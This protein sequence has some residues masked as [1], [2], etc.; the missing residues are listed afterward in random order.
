[1]I[2]HILFDLDGTLLP[3]NQDK[4]IKAYFSGI[5]KQIAPLGYDPNGLIEG[6]WKGTYNMIK[7]DGSKTNETVFLENFSSIFG[8]KVYYDTYKFDEF[9]EKYFD[10]VKIS[11]GYNKEAELLIDKLKEMNFNLILATNPIF[12]RIAT[13]KRIAWAGLNK[14]DFSYISVYQNSH[15]CK[16]NLR[17]YEEILN[18]LNLNP[19]ECLMIGNDVGEDMVVTSL[20]MKV[21]LLTDCLINKNNED[22]NKYPHGSFNELNE[23]IDNLN[24]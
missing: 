1:M 11:C 19:E 22:I 23:F 7:N 17:Y 12:P 8:K 16:P 20:N 2:K 6:I 9:Y 3:M 13:E 10:E 4:F 5:V 14:N 18:K 24:K 15:S 21:F